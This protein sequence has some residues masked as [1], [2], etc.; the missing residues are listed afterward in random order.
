MH[1][2]RKKENSFYFS[3]LDIL[4]ELNNLSEW[5]DDELSL[6]QDEKLVEKAGSTRRMLKISFA[7]SIAKLCD[8]YPVEFPHEEFNFENFLFSWYTI[9]A[10]AFGRRLPWTALVPFADCLNHKNVQTKYDYKPIDE[11]GRDKMFRLFLTGNNRY[12]KGTEAFNSYG[13]RPNDNLLLEYGFA[14]LDNEW[15]VIPVQL[16]LTKKFNLFDDK[17]ATLCSM[18]RMISKTFY[19]NTRNVHGDAL[20]FARLCACDSLKELDLFQRSGWEYGSYCKAISLTNEMKALQIF[21]EAVTEMLQKNLCNETDLE[22]D[23]RILTSINR[24]SARADVAKVIDAVDDYSEIA[25]NIFSRENRLRP[26]LYY[27][28]T[29]KRIALE[30][31]RKSNILID[32]LSS[33]PADL[34]DVSPADFIKFLAFS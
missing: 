30:I 1:E 11:I 14:M 16:S 23:L 28:I 5:E 33:I 17:V 20:H 8:M 18:R 13:R 4:P 10:R 12:A 34:V 19:V 27:R 6:L 25:K 32:I 22:S 15:D 2:R 21:A 29:R 7:K 26:A 9:Q 24:Q 31:I 3:Y